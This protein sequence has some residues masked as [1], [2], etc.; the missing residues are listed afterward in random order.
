ML[1]EDGMD[2][3]IIKIKPPLCFTQENADM[4]LEAIDCAIGRIK[5]KP[6]GLTT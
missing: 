1:K 6:S 3:N 2:E 4:V 5:K